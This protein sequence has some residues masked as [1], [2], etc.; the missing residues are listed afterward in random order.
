MVTVTDHF[1]WK[2]LGSRN[3]AN[4]NYLF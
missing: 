3:W 4:I 2:I 1:E